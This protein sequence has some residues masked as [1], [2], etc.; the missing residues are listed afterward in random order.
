MGFLLRLLSKN[1]LFVFFIFLQLIAIVLIF[2]RNSMQQSWIA[3]QSAAF[4]SWVSGY[5]DEGASYLKLKQTNE[6]L[7]A[8]N[9]SL[10]QELYGKDAANHPEFRKVHDTIGGGQIYTFVDGDIV[11]NSINRKDN[12]FTINRGLRDGVLPKMG[13]MAPG[14][15]AGIVINS[16][17]SY[18]LVQSILSLNKIKINAALKKSGYFGTLTWRGDDSRIMHLSDIPKYVPLQV[19]DTIVTDGKSAIFPQGIMVG[20]IAGYEV[21]S[22][23]GFW[24]ISV[25]LSEKMGNLSKIYVVKNLKKA[26]VRKIED[27]LQATIKREK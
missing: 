2:S 23:T 24:D 22:K 11:F 19:G 27:T 10:M 5:I 17:D 14:G 8:Q 12:Y 6:Q 25:E 21:D 15:I 1:G 18:S 3:G 26:E 7:V 4:N 13:V 9:K 20:K 16:T